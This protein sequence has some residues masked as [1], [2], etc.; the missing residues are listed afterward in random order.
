MFNRHMLVLLNG[1]PTKEFVVVRGL[2]QGVLLAPFLFLI[3]VEGLTSMCHK[4]VRNGDFVGYQ[5]SNGLK[6]DILQFA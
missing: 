1:S 3:I 2:W 5:V 6:F 4:V